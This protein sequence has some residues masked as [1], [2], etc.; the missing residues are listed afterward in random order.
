MV[1]SD[2]PKL[3]RL[4]PDSL[5]FDPENPRFGGTL[6]G[7][8]QTEI[9]KAIFGEPHYASELVDSFLENGFID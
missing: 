1:K 5:D 8:S 6:E 2:N 4:S 9:Q 3:E 7:K